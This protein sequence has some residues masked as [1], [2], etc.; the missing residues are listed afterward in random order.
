MHLIVDLGRSL[1]GVAG[2]AASLAAE[3]G[4]AAFSEPHEPQSI[5]HAVACN[6]LAGYLGRFL[7]VVGSTGSW[8]LEDELLGGATAGEHGNLIP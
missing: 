6:H 5:V 4:V 2:G 3:E 1:V 7:E 8:V